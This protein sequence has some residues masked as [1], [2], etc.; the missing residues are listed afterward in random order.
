MKSD[1]WDVFNNVPVVLDYRI[2]NEATDAKDPDHLERLSRHPDPHV[3][4]RVA[5]NGLTPISVLERLAEERGEAAEFVHKYLV[6]NPVVPFHILKKLM[7][8]K[9]PSLRNKIYTKLLD[10]YKLARV[11]LA[12][13]E[14]YDILT[15]L[16]PDLGQLEL[17][18]LLETVHE[19]HDAEKKKRI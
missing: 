18:E 9:D 10:A 13:N 17:I 15:E 1:H 7:Y 11:E 12:G 3:R 14:V 6:R 8:V 19:I 5:E 16:A 4:A 2:I